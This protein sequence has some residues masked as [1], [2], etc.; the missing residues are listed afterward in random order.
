MHQSS[1]KQRAERCTRI[2]SKGSE[3]LVLTKLISSTDTTVRCDTLLAHRFVISQTCAVVS[4]INRWVSKYLLYLITRFRVYK[5]IT[6][7]W[8]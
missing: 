3:V 4:L 5:R 2:S 1:Y 7:K 8:R 6:W